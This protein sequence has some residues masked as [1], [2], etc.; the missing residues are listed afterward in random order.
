MC[1]SLRR[2]AC[3]PDYAPNLTK[4]KGDDAL[5]ANQ[6]SSPKFDPHHAEIPYAGIIKI[7]RG[8]YVVDPYTCAK[9]RHDPP[10]GFVCAPNCTPKSVSFLGLLAIRYSQ[11]PWTDFG[12][13]EHKIAVFGINSLTDCPISAKLCTRKQNS[14]PTKAT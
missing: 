6:W 2:S 14:M 1:F 10:R 12:G 3:D 5:D 11:R 13:R 8:D 7:G 9:V 4:A